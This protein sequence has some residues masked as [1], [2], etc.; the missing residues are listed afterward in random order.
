M[1]VLVP[2][3]EMEQELASGDWNW[4]IRSYDGT[5]VLGRSGRSFHDRQEC[6]ADL[7]TFGRLVTAYAVAQESQMACMV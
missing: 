3:I 2:R 4:L 7:K 6:I 1:D 5:V